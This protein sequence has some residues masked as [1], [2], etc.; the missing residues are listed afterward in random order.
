LDASKGEAEKPGFYAFNFNPQEENPARGY[1]MSANHQPQPPSGVPVP[2]YYNL[3]DRARRLDAVLSNPKTLWD[4]KAAQA[5]QL[6]TSNG[7][8]RRILQNLLPVMQSVVTDPNEK[9]F[10]E[11]LE[12][13]DGNYTTD[14]IAATLF[15]QML[16]ELSKAAMEDEM[17]EVQFKNLLSTRALDSALPLLVADPNSPWW[18]NKKTKATESH[19]ETVRIAWSNTLKHLQGLYGTSLLDW[20]WGVAHTVTHGHPLG[21]QKPLHLLF[22]VGPFPAPGGRETPNNLSNPIG[23]APWAVTYGPSTRRVIDFADASRAV[24]IN[25]V[26]QSGVL[27]DSHYADQAELYIAGGYVPQHLSE[28]DVRAHTKSKLRFK[29]AP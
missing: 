24:G 25:P 4:S 19:F 17:G 28:D 10:M 15:S 20:R 13:W 21:R 26:G 16:Y 12:K 1:I 18:D 22:N 7:Y 8:G 2:G 3:P 14:S 5:L 11:P 29:P 23:P 6:D 9:A 27:F